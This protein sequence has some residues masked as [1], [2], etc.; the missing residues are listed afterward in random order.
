MKR[1]I[2]ICAVVGLFVTNAYSLDIA[3]QFYIGNVAFSDDRTVDEI[4]LPSVF[5]W[6]GSAAVHQQ[7]NDQIAFT[8][9]FDSDPTLNFVSYTLLD[10]NL[11]YFSI[12]VGPFFGLF[13]SR[14]TLLKPGISTAVR[15][16]IPGIAFVAFRADASIGGRLVQ[17]GDYL[18][19]RSDVSLGFYV[20][21]AIISVNLLTKSYIYLTDDTEVVDNYLE[22]SFV[23]DLYQKNVPYRISLSFGY[24]ERG[25]SFVSVADRTDTTVHR[26]RSIVLGTELE[27][28]F[29]DWLLLEI[30]LDSSIYSFGDAGDE[31][32]ALPTS[33]IGQYL[34]NAAIGVRIDADGLAA[35]GSLPLRRRHDSRA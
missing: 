11:Q 23:T 21:N 7:I 5:S 13:N 14:N 33:G 4:S 26:L 20:R 8:L 1:F 12:I 24:Q 6:G 3:T 30:D 17:T 25:K 32:L 22:Y 34:F 9:T 29:S 16:D 35:R 18:Q 31:L 19:E 2:A 27:I 28:Q 10:Y 15:A